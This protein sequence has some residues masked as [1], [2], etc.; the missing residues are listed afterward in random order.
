M[1]QVE[2]SGVDGPEVDRYLLWKGEKDKRDYG[3]VGEYLYGICLSQVMCVRG[4]AVAAFLVRVRMHIDNTVNDMLV[5][6]E[7]NGTSVKNK[8]GEECHLYYILELLSH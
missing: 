2:N 7:S 4:I 5:W 3:Y 1:Q 6:K 8:N